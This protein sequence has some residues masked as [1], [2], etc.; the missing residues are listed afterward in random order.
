[1]ED[2]HSHHLGLFFD[3]DWNRHDSE[4]SFGHD[5]EAS[6]L[7]M[8]TALVLGDK[9]IVDNALV[10][11]RN[12]A[13]AALQGRCVDGSMVYERYGNGH[14]CN[15]KHWWVQA[16]CVIGQIYLYRF[17]GIENAAMMAAQT[18][19]YIKRNIADY[20]VG[21]WFWSHNADGSVN[22]TDDKAGFRKCPYH[23]SRMCLEVYSILGE[24]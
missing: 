5:I 19:D 10:H 16:E 13:E 2:T 6:W 4:Q 11:T 22:R 12:I 17:H 7:L 9:D 23:N 3:E 18:W 1:M 8:E 20:D 21:E 14:Y 24:M 15:D